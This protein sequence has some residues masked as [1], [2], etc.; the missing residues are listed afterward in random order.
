[1]RFDV[2]AH[3]RF[4]IQSETVRF[5]F[6]AHAKKFADNAEIFDFEWFKASK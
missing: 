1:M 5:E 3:E 6:N 2:L 4:L